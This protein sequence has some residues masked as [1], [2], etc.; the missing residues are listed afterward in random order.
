MK[1]EEEKNQM[2]F[3]YDELQTPIITMVLFIFFQMPYFKTVLSNY[4]HNYFVVM[5]TQLWGVF[6]LNL[7]Y[8]LP[9]II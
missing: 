9:F 3:L 7:F 1:K 4:F 8:L 6:C 2:D 5:V